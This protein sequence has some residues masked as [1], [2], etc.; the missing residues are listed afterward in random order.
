MTSP[1]D[2]IRQ[3][4]TIPTRFINAQPEEEP[5]GILKKSEFDGNFYP[6]RKVH[7]ADDVGDLDSLTSSGSDTS[8]SE[9]DM[10]SSLENGPLLVVK[11]TK[12]LSKTDEA[13]LRGQHLDTEDESCIDIQ[14]I[15]EDYIPMNVKMENSKRSEVKD[16]NM[17]NLKKSEVKDKHESKVTLELGD[18]GVI[19]EV[20]TKFGDT[21][22]TIETDGANSP[23]TVG[24][25]SVPNMEKEKTKNCEIDTLQNEQGDI[26]QK[27]LNNMEEVNNDILNGTDNVPSEISSTQEGS[28][29]VVPRDKPLLRKQKSYSVSDVTIC[30]K[31]IR[32]KVSILRYLHLSFSFFVIKIQR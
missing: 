18:N 14:E 17:A 24:S 27:H 1:E 11:E 31:I 7:F 32:L 4:L 3:T 2:N 15:G 9:P 19:T 20:S 26:K 30:T 6:N 5:S 28:S 16:N 25:S 12:Y 29:G 8:D 22:V 21:D 10:T 13:A 23:V